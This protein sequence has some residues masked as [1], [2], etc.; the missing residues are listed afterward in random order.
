MDTYF[1]EAKAFIFSFLVKKNPRWRQKKIIYKMY[2]ARE[3][4]FM[5]SGRNKQH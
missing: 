4:P 5:Y 3:F 1:D 2:N